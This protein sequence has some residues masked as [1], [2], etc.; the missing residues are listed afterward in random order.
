MGMAYNKGWRTVYSFIV[1]I[2]LVTKY[3][4][5]VINPSLLQRLA[6]IFEDTLKKWESELVEFNGKCEHDH[7]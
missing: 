1:H 7:I 4:R 2:A 6:E 3:R 5:K